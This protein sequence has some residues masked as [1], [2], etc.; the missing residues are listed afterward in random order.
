MWW[1]AFMNKNKCLK[2]AQ[3]LN[4]QYKQ[5][6]W[7]PPSQLLLAGSLLAALTQTR[8]LLGVENYKQLADVP[9]HT[10]LR[11][12]FGMKG[13]RI[14][15]KAVSKTKSLINTYEETERHTEKCN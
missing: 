1:P 5:E 7:A 10:C 12:V 14:K 2:K 13:N 4:F 8:S 9:K 6:H 15:D 3:V 11:C